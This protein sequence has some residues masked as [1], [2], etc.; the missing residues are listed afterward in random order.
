MSVAC[1]EVDDEDEDDDG[2]GGACEGAHDGA[3]CE[4][5][6]LSSSCFAVACWRLARTAW[7]SRKMRL[8]L[9]SAPSSGV[10]VFAPLLAVAAMRLQLPRLFAFSRCSMLLTLFAALAHRA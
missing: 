3:A 2:G 1:F 5:A 8:K 7:S 9:P 4:G 10:A 6:S